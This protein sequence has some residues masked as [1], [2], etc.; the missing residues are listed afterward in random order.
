MLADIKPGPSSSESHALK[1]VGNN[2]FFVANDGPHG[3][4]LW[5]TDGTPTGTLMLKDIMPG[6]EHSNINSSVSLGNVL[7]F[8]ARDSAWNSELWRSD[9]TP[10]GTFKVKEINPTDT[11][12]VYEV[13]KWQGLAYFET[14]GIGNLTPFKN[15]L[16]FNGGA[17][18]GI[19][20]LWRTDGT[21]VGTAMVFDVNPGKAANIDDMVVIGDTLYFTAVHATYGRE[22]WASDGTAAKLVRDIYPGE[23]GSYPTGLTAFAN[24]LFFYASDNQ[25]GYEL[26]QAKNPNEAT[27][28]ADILPGTDG[29]ING[30]P[31]MVEFKNA[32][33]FNADD[34]HHGFE[35]WRAAEKKPIVKPAPA[36]PKV[37]IARGKV[38]L[39]ARGRLKIKLA[40]EVAPCKGQLT[41][42]T[43]AKVATGKR[44]RKRR[45]VLTPKPFMAPD[46]RKMTVTVPLKPAAAKLLRT[47][48]AARRV[49]VTAK[50]QGG[51]TV[52]RVVTVKP[53]PTKPKKKRRK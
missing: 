3:Q 34:G 21:D 24:Q 19:D 15:H 39:D 29:S 12:T 50:L 38:V 7:L 45:V 4:E 11:G 5:R 37:K 2:A 47:S 52:T 1:V 48:R 16:Y 41:L 51:P 17:V 9:G 44:G 53:Q 18:Y 30:I 20:Q 13:H 49:K 22:L 43:A 36:K 26:W 27:L 8:S 32:L 31:P 10:A 46:A 40:C 28:F 25:L 35:L 6:P 42:A 14:S 33:Y 23:E